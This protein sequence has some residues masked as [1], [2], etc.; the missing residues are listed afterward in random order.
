MLVIVVFHSCKKSE[1]R[2]GD[3]Q[4][5]K[6]SPENVDEYLIE[7][8][9]RM[10]SSRKDL[11]YISLSDAE[12][13]LT[14]LQNF[15]LC[16]ASYYSSEMI[17]D[18]LYFEIET[19]NDSISLFELNNVFEYN[20]HN[21]VDKYNKMDGES[22]SI[23]YINTKIDNNSRDGI[24]KVTTVSMMYN[25]KMINSY[26]NRFGPTDYWYDFD[27]KGK[28]SDYIW[29]CEG[30]DATTEINSKLQ[31]YI[32][33][34]ECNGRIYFTNIVELSINTIT[35][36]Y[37][38]EDSPYPPYCLYVGDSHYNNCL[39]PEELN[40]YLDKVLEI[41]EDYENIYQKHLVSAEIIAGEG[42]GFDKDVT[43]DRYIR[44]WHLSA[45]LADINCTPIS[46][47]L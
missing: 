17:A 39:S 2:C 38:C 13:N 44:Y 27:G 37:E 41:L 33:S 32:P 46:P 45:W 23:Y 26:P 30:R 10:K 35:D 12:W 22:K 1:E 7:F 42:V 8:K 16:D 29:Q 11:E 28:C 25:N 3:N 36:Y 47:N 5:L 21:I 34:Y 24:A 4:N 6:T 15:E 14:A 31:S 43:N 18:T 20:V 9:K 40:W 19:K